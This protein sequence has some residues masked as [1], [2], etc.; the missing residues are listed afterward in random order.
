LTWNGR[1]LRKKTTSAAGPYRKNR[2]QLMND[3][4][5]WFLLTYSTGMPSLQITNVLLASISVLLVFSVN[6]LFRRLFNPLNRFPGPALARWTRFYAAY[7]DIYK[8]GAWIEQLKEL[9]RLYGFC[10]SSVF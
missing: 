10:F 1:F 3:S 5:P 6:F 2:E 4:T 7:Y 8:G 9:H